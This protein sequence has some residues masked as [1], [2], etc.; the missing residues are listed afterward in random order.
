MNSGMIAPGNHWYFESAARS[1]TIEVKFS[2][3]TLGTAFPTEV[4][5]YNNL[6]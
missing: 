6:L 1:T 2:E 4:F 3:V 5:L